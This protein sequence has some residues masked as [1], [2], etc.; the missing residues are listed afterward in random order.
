[1]RH[2]C[3]VLAY[4]PLI[5]RL[6]SNS[7]DFHNSLSNAIYIYIYRIDR[8]RNPAGFWLSF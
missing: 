7:C 2:I 5:R 3:L 1:M 4:W 6:S 8:K